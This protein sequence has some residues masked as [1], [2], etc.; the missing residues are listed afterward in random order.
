MRLII[1]QYPIMT[2]L[3]INTSNSKEPHELEISIKMTINDYFI[4]E[5]Q[6]LKL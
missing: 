4:K 6:A 2:R 3:Y 5:R 1:G